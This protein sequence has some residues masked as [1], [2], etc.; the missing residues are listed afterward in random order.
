MAC[1]LSQLPFR[2]DL[3]WRL[4]VVLDGLQLSLSLSEQRQRTDSVASICMLFVLLMSPKHTTNS[5]ACTYRPLSA[6]LC[7]T[8]SCDGGAETDPVL[9]PVS[10][11]K[12]LQEH[13]GGEAL[14]PCLLQRQESRCADSCLTIRHETLSVS[15]KEW[16]G[17]LR[18]CRAYG[19][20]RHLLSGGALVSPPHHSPFAKQPQHALGVPHS[21]DASLI[22]LISSRVSFCS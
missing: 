11:G 18:I 21:A 6:F 3:L 12:S 5:E 16:W 15:D 8:L 14:S 9:V 7:L 10:N 1:M 19:E 22:Q 13:Q 2:Y 17:I 4:K 20:S